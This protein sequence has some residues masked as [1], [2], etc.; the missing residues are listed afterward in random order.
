MVNALG[1][2]FLHGTDHKR[3]F[4]PAQI[5]E[6]CTTRSITIHIR[7]ILQTSPKRNG[8]ELRLWLRHLNC[9]DNA[10]RR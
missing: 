10:V 6:P 7:L 9:F 2:I 4:H 1:I 5:V 3:G 8:L